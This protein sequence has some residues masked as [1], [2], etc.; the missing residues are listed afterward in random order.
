[1]STAD[2]NLR[3]S[4]ADADIIARDVSGDRRKTLV[5]GLLAGCSNCGRTVTEH[6]TVT[7]LT[8]L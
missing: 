1:M 5:E 2:G 6:P 8:W 4:A 3:M 7:C